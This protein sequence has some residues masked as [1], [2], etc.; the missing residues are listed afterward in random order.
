MLAGM[1]E[2]MKEQQARSDSNRQQATLECENIVREQEALK[3][4]NDQLQTQ[5]AALQSTQAQMQS[6]DEP[7]RQG[8]QVDGPITNLRWLRPTSPL[9]EGGFDNEADSPRFRMEV[10]HDQTRRKIK[11]T[12]IRTL[13]ELVQ[14]QI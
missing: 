5:V 2:Q 3:Q 8:M 1:K 11:F 4:L 9:H 7:E 12:D 14:R 13:D 10:Q 6:E